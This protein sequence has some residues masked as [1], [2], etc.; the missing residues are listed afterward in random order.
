MSRAPILDGDRFAPVWGPRD[1]RFALGSVL[2]GIGLWAFGW[3]RSSGTADIGETVFGV[4]LGAGAVGVVAS[5]GVSWVS[6]GHR[7]V[8]ARRV[9]VVALLEDRI[10]LGSDTGATSDGSVLVSVAGTARFHR[11]DCLLVRGKDV[12]MFP[13]EFR[14]LRRRIPCEMCCP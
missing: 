12:E 4:V 3:W 5:A 2:A 1:V 14:R 7:A 6:A 10:R 13:A 9:E 8:L 11:A